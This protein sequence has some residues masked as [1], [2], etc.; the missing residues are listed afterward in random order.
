MGRFGTVEGGRGEKRFEKKVCGGGFINFSGLKEGK[1]LSD[2]MARFTR[3]VALC[4]WTQKA[5]NQPLKR[6]P[7]T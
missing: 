3:T 7:R 5:K 4:T 2:S 6:P 1:K